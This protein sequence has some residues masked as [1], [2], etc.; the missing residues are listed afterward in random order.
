M[1][2]KHDIHDLII[3]ILYYFPKEAQWDEIKFHE[4]LEIYYDSSI[5]KI[6]FKKIEKNT[7]SDEV[8]KIFDLLDFSG[9]LTRKHEI[10]RI[11][12]ELLKGHYETEIKPTFTNKEL[13][14]IKELSLKMQENM[15]IIT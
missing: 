11:D 7:Y 1:E 6:K 5:I 13:E 4:A 15:G 2:E 10:T 12:L 8:G 9:I 14:K 3:G